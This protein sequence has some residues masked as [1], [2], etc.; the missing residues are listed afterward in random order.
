MAE[1]YCK[2][3]NMSVIDHLWFLCWLLW[4][5]WA[6]DDVRWITSVILRADII[7]QHVYADGKKTKSE[8]TCPDLLL[9][10]EFY[11]QDFTEH[12]LFKWINSLMK[13]HL[14]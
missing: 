3:L 8:W 6:I 12:T 7:N 9:K 13:T 10:S 5:G 2:F 14:R 4:A 11:D 1:T